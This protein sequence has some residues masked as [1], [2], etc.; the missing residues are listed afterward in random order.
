MEHKRQNSSTNNE[1]LK[2][3]GV[4]N[5]IVGV[6]VALQNE[7]NGIGRGGKE[8]DLHDSVVK[9]KSRVPWLCEEKVDVAGRKYNHV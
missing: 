2:S 9:S 6:F 1:K 8:E 3:K 4:M 7:V 5:A